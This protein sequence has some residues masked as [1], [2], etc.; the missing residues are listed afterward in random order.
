MQKKNKLS[1]SKKAV[2]I[3]AIIAGA[4]LLIGLIAFLVVGFKVE[5]FATNLVQ[6][7]EQ[8]IAE[9]F[10]NIDI[11]SISADISVF[12]S[13]D[14]NIKISY[15]EDK[16]TKYNLEIKDGTLLLIPQKTPVN[17]FLDLINVN[18]MEDYIDLYLPEKMFESLGDISLKATSGDLSWVNC[19]TNAKSLTLKCTSGNIFIHNIRVGGKVKANATS[20]EIQLIGID[21][22]N[23]D[24]NSTSGNVFASLFTPKDYKVKT[25]SGNYKVPE[26]KGTGVFKCNV[27]SGNVTVKVNPIYD[28]WENPYE[29]FDEYEKADKEKQNK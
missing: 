3:G 11:S 9:E 18:I 28:A 12:P 17:N 2:I 15:S 4:G 21:A 5:N 22:K 25:T 23:F 19:P 14:D 6:T 1:A 13:E 8:I 29:N 10:S 26:E 27:T 24:I 20:G 7:K 16:R